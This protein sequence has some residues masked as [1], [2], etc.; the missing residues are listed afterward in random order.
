MQKQKILIPTNVH[1]CMLI[2]KFFFTISLQLLYLRY[3]APFEIISKS[4]FKVSS[5]L[6]S[7]P[8]LFSSLMS[9]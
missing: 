5:Q 6:F 3:T 4:G 7:K 2:Y 9:E 1:A 8:N